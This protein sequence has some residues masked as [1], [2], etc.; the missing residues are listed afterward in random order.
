MQAKTQSF[1]KVIAHELRTMIVAEPKSVGSA[2]PEA[3]EVLMDAL[4]EGFERLEAGGTLDGMNADA[5]GR[6]MVHGGE[7]GDLAVLEGKH[8]VGTIV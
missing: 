1:L 2:G 3:P 4:A 7:D 8:P 6:A 5:L